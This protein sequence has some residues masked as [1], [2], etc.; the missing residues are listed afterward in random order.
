[1][2]HQHLTTQE[3]CKV[4]SN[5]ALVLEIQKRLEKAD[6]PLAKVASLVD[7]APLFEQAYNKE[8]YDLGSLD[9]RGTLEHIEDLAP[10]VEDEEDKK[11]LMVLIRSAMKMYDKEANAIQEYTDK[12]LEALEG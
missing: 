1:M 8:V 3:L 6:T 12:L 2:Q 10:I 4:P 7:N 5:D 9:I 11:R